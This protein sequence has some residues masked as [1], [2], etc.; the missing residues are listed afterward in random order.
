MHV[1]YQAMCRKNT[2]NNK[3]TAEMNVPRQSVDCFAPNIL[4]VSTV[5]EQHAQHIHS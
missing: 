4:L 3:Q 5:Y 2:N 1:P